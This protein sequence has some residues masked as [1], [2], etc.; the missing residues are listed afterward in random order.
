MMLSGSDKLSPSGSP[1]P[2]AGATRH[3]MALVA[4]PTRFRVPTCSPVA[5]YVSVLCSSSPCRRVVHAQHAQFV[6]EKCAWTS[7][8]ACFLQPVRSMQPQAAAAHEIVGTLQIWLLPIQR[9]CSAELLAT[10][11]PLRW[12]RLP[13]FEELQAR[14]TA[15]CWR[16]GVVAAQHSVNSQH[17]TS[18]HNSNHCRT[19]PSNVSQFLFCLSALCYCRGSRLVDHLQLLHQ[20]LAPLLLRF[21]LQCHLLA[22]REKPFAVQ[23]STRR[24]AIEAGLRHGFGV[25]KGVYH[26]HGFEQT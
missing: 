4:L 24:W 6:R 22:V 26:P 25:G 17:T 8:G 12:Q 11:S 5:C 7:A 9:L 13:Q 20:I 2:G 18:W 23:L 19:H 14:V 1:P 3:T 15:S 21:H 16:A 10:L